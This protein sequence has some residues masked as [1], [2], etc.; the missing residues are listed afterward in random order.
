MSNYQYTGPYERTYPAI[1][2]DAGS[3]VVQPGDVRE[4]D[5]AP[6]DGLWVPVKAD[7]QAKED[8]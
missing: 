7:K 4:F 3:L 8:A 5:E 6:N 2:T 1:L